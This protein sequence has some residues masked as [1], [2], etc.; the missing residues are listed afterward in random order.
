MPTY[1][2]EKTYKSG[3]YDNWKDINGQDTRTYTAQD[4]RKPYDVVFSDGV[5]PEEDGTAGAQA[6]RPEQGR[7][8]GHG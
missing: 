7:G 5:M 2:M 6:L 8:A 3:F 1:Q 4:M